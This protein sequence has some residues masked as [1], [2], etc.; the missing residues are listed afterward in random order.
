MK[1]TSNHAASLVGV[2]KI[3]PAWLLAAYAKETAAARTQQVISKSKAFRNIL[4]SILLLNTLMFISCTDKVVGPQSVDITPL[5]HLK[6]A[7]GIKTLGPMP[8]FKKSVEHEVYLETKVKAAHGIMEAFQNEFR[9]DYPNNEY[10]VDL[11]A[12]RALR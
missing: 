9:R 6:V 1:R 7:Q 4:T 5:S 12:N 11:G 2:M 8:G 3:P 10:T